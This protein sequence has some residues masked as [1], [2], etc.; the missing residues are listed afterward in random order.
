[1]VHPLSD[2]RN[3]AGRGAEWRRRPRYVFIALLSRGLSVRPIAGARAAAHAGAASA[4]DRP[5]QHAAPR[6]GALRSD[7][8][9]RLR[10]SLCL[11]CRAA[12]AVVHGQGR[13]VPDEALGRP[14]RLLPGV[15]GRPARA[16]PRRVAARRSAAAGGP[17]TGRV[18]RRAHLRDRRHAPGVARSHAAG[19]TD[20]RTGGAGGHGG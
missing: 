8:S 11:Q 19:A 13:A 7:P 1:M 9:L 17:R 12:P 6:R 5:P 15:F 2:A 16:R 20:R 3:R 4:R 18:P 14:D 10:P